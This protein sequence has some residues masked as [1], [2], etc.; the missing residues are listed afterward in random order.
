MK[1][2]ETLDGTGKAPR[3]IQIDYLKHLESKLSHYDV[4][5]LEAP[6]G[7]GKSFLARTI[8]RVFSP[9]CAI[10]TNNNLLVDQYTESYPE[11]NGVKGKD[12]YPTMG[13]YF[14]AR[15]LADSHDNV[16]NPL[17]F[18]Y[19]YLMK[20][21]KEGIVNKPNVIIIDE[22]HRLADM[23]LL[24]IDQS[25]NC[26]YY[27]IPNNLDDKG[28][29]N[30]LKTRVE[31]LEVFHG[32]QSKL[33]SQF[34]KLK[35]MYDYLKANLHTVK[36]FYEMK[37]N[38]KGIKQ[39][40]MCI[41]PI[42][43]PIGLLDTIF[44]DARLILFSGSFTKMH[45]DELFPKRK[46]DYKQYEPLAKI[47]NMPIIY[48]PIPKEN[49]NN[50]KVIAENVRRIYR[51][52]DKPNTLV[53]V[54]YS[55]STQLAPLLKDL[56]VMTHTKETKLEAVEEFKQK[57]GILLACG[58]A[59]GVDLPDDFCR[60]II[61]PK[62]IYPNRG[63]QAVAKRLALS[64]GQEWYSVETAMTTVQQL[65]R[66]VR[67]PTDACTSYIL[68]YTFPRLIGSVEQFLTNGLKAAIQWSNP[69]EKKQK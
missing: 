56:N 59:E 36:T 39:L 11:L 25:L 69:Y 40:H 1:F 51:R 3:E 7:V 67:G 29:L 34:E 6:P 26:R 63:D 12:H 22:A 47:E 53:H 41:R 38:Y 64:N 44:E 24:T 45:C 19:Y 8:Q 61:I 32:R 18:Y 16:F 33:S 62:L 15:E 20:R 54:T 46:V 43:L 14:K 60:L 2:L 58:M 35:I 50:I 49:R 27:G 55:L 10:L 21:R 37:E 13:E 23:L 4:H 30:W 17:S 5:V 57:G 31:K 28:F 66:G 65:G 9:N 48:E 68:D 42:E 52:H